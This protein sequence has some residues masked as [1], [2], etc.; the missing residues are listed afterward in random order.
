ME[1]VLQGDF[2]LAVHQLEYSEG[3]IVNSKKQHYKQQ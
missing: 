3:L 1:D 2:L